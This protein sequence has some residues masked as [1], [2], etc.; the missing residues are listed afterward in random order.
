MFVARP[1][2][3]LALAP[4]AR[5]LFASGADVKHALVCCC[6]TRNLLATYSMKSLMILILM[7]DA[8]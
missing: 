7:N 2:A 1:Q 5:L 6:G 8:G 4:A 3:A